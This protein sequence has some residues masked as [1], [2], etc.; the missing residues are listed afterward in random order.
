MP[1]TNFTGITTLT[2]FDEVINS[3]LTYKLVSAGLLLNYI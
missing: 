1:I 2:I 3:F